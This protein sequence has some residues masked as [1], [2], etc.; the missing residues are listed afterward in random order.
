MEW[1]VRHG[2]RSIGEAE[3][4]VTGVAFDESPSREKINHGG[5]ETRRGGPRKSEIGD[6]HFD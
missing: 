6:A 3:I 2:Y 4:Q 1:L 5:T